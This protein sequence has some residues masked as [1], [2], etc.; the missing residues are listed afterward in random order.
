MN[1][2]PNPEQW[3]AYLIT[4][5]PGP[6]PKG[7]RGSLRRARERHKLIVTS[8]VMKIISNG[9]T[10]LFGGPARPPQKIRFMRAR[11]LPA[12]QTRV[13]DT[14]LQDALQKG[15][16]EKG[17]VNMTHPIFAVPKPSGGW[18]VVIDMRKLN[19][20]LLAPR[21]KL[22]SIEDAAALAQPRGFA[23][24]IDLTDA[25]HHIEY[26]EEAR[27][28]SGFEWRGAR[29]RY[30]VLPFGNRTS[31]WWL[32]RVLNPTI[33][34][35]R[36]RGI[37]IVVYVD[38]MLILGD[39]AAKVKTDTLATVRALTELGWHINYDKSVLVPQQKI[40]FLGYTL[41]LSGWPAIGL[42]PLK[43]RRIAHELSRASR[44]QLVRPRIL[45]RVVGLAT[46]AS[47]AV[48]QVHTFVRQAAIEIQ[49]AVNRGGYSTTMTLSRKAREDLATLAA[50][51]RQAKPRPFTPHPTVEVRTD[52]SLLGMGA[53]LMNPSN[54]RLPEV[55]ES[56]STRVE[57]PAHI[58]VLELRAAFLALK[59]WAP[60]LRNQVVSLKM[61]NMVAL[62]YVRRGTGKVPALRKLAKRI[63]LLALHHNIT[64]APC[65]IPSTGNVLADRESRRVSPWIPPLIAAA[66]GI[67]G[68]VARPWPSTSGVS[69]EIPPTRALKGAL[70]TPIW[71]SAPWWPLLKREALEMVPMP[72]PLTNIEPHAFVARSGVMALW[73]FSSKKFL[74]CR[75]PIELLSCPT[76]P[77]GP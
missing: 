66:L 72:V 4:S 15:Y 44:S 68:P 20:H 9:A 25:F 7:V 28:W 26:N 60:M 48:P 56:W 29:Y 64:L 3:R 62:S 76:V 17:V 43:R 11:S 5:P 33:R 61:D 65:F 32:T 73:N 1:S 8:F 52:A 55:I 19:Q 40:E 13:I 69:R 50:L 59:K 47:K 58:N 37:S 42:P 75:I 49:S 45:A 30:A 31:P 16:V 63:V 18:R 35:L 14:W 41:D 10:M 34:S 27:R 70:I 67:T 22:P 71:K 36:L 6:L 39:S 2:E 21:F 77:P 54:Q 38:D 57:N 46:S 23:T 51:V 12:D 53:V 74:R 24:K